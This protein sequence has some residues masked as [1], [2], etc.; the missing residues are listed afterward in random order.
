MADAGEIAVYRPTSIRQSLS[1]WA[2]GER[3][4]TTLY[5]AVSLRQSLDVWAAGE[6]IT[7]LLQR[8]VSWRVRVPYYVGGTVA[9]HLLSH[10]SRLAGTVLVNGEQQS[11]KLVL[12]I[13]RATLRIIDST[14]SDE[15]GAWEFSELYPDGQYLVLAFDTLQGTPGYNALIADYLTPVPA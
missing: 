1:V 14:V 5:R 7:S 6:R 13:Y 15:N 8:R 9:A 3:T 4:V 11:G 2:A 10:Q 12:L